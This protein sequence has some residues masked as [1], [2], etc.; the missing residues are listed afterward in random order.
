MLDS[1]GIPK[2]IDGVIS[3]SVGLITWSIIKTKDRLDQVMS[4]L[5]KVESEKITEDKAR[6]I[7]TSELKDIKQT[8][9]KI[10]ETVVEIR[11]DQAKYT[12]EKK[13]K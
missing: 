5:T 8:L 9:H 11:V 10:A 12:S 2:V 6:E 3:L 1:V 7:I 4:R 13:H